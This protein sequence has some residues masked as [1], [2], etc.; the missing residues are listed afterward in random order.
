MGWSQR[1]LEAEELAFILQNSNASGLVSEAKTLDENTPLADIY[2]LEDQNRKK[3]V[4][5]LLDASAILG[6]WVSS[7][8]PLAPRCYV[9][10]W[11][12]CRRSCWSTEYHLAA[13]GDVLRLL[14][15]V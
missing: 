1:V 15:V 12:L 3:N 5:V 14:E 7:P 6:F 4:V 11:D 8:S 2:S 10:G 9:L 13:D